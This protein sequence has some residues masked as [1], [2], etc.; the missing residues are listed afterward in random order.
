MILARSFAWNSSTVGMMSCCHALYHRLV[1]V[2]AHEVAEADCEVG[3]SEELVHLRE[4][5]GYELRC[6]RGAVDREPS[7]QDVDVR[8]ELDEV[9]ATPQGE[10]HQRNAPVCTIHRADQVEIP[11]QA[12]L[13]L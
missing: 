11:W 9:E 4:V 13:A 10:I 12:Q 3:A 8:P 1:Q 2:L 5:V 7:P 6:G